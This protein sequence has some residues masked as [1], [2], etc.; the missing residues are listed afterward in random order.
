MFSKKI[1]DLLRLVEKNFKFKLPKNQS[2]DYF[3]VVDRSR[4]LP[5]LTLS[6]LSSNIIYKKRLKPIL[7]SD[8]K[9]N[10]PISKI[11]KAFGVNTIYSSFNKLLFFNNIF[12][13]VSCLVF[14]LLGLIQIKI[15][16]FKWFIE[17]FRVH[18]IL[19]GDLVF[20][21]YVRNYNH[22]QNPK[23]DTRF[24]IILF[25]AIFRTKRI[26]KLFNER[27]IKFTLIPTSAYVSNGAIAARVALENK[28][29]VIEPYLYG[30]REITKQL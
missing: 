10:H 3:L 25:Q 28:I 27:N 12:L 14:T 20:D 6:L 5:T 8:L 7:I 18:N 21:S 24:L 9:P 16:S 11:F 23:T 1:D 2:K 13:S 22:Y 30:S 19:V 15:R 4:Y 26:T 29:R 17:N